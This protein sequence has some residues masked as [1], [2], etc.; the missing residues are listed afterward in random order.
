MELWPAVLQPPVCQYQP[1]HVSESEQGSIFAAWL[2]VPCRMVMQTGRKCR[3]AT[4]KLPASANDEGRH[5]HADCSQQQLKPGAAATDPDPCWPHVCKT[6][7]MASEI[8]PQALPSSG[9]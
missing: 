9:S 4:I 3:H 6:A 2:L 8:C 7:C 1:A 5:V